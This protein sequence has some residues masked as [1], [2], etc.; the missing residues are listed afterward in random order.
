MSVFAAIWGWFAALD[1]R[2]WQAIIAGIFLAFGWIVNGMQNRRV[3]ARFRKE[4]LRDA[5]RAIFAEIAPNLANLWDE[6][7]LDDHA[8]TLIAQMEED[9]NFLPFIPKERND[10]LFSA[11]QQ[12]IWILPRVTIDP[13]VMYY[14]IL[15]A[16]DS[17][18]DDMRGDSF[19]ALPQDRR[20][21]IYRDYIEMRKQLLI[22]GRI[23]NHLISIYARDGKKAAEEEAARLAPYS[24]QPL[25]SS[26]TVDRSAT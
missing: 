5:H 14:V 13:V 21:A 3:A 25:P 16:V 2:I 4:K 26:L 8:A 22:S 17:L 23:A 11:I 18:T 7:A 9:P 12:E 1:P 24:G 15:D 19:A 6:T 10:R 20:I